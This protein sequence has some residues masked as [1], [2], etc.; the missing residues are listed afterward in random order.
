LHELFLR[1]ANANDIG[2]EGTTIKKETARK[3]NVRAL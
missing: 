1:T 2:K 3:E